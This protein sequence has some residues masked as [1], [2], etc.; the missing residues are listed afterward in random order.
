MEGGTKKVPASE[1][2]K[3]GTHPTRR[4]DVAAGST[5][6]DNVNYHPKRTNRQLQPDRQSAAS[7]KIYTECHYVGAVDQCILFYD[8]VKPAGTARGR[9]SNSRAK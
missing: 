5:L 9:T 7:R 4:A 2:V 6:R 3:N 1:Q 8:R